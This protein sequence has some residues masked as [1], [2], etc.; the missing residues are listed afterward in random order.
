MQTRMNNGNEGVCRVRA[1]ALF[2]PLRLCAFALISF[3][4]VNAIRAADWPQWRGPNRDGVVPDSKLP[5]PLP[6]ELKTVWRVEIGEG[7]SSPI[8]VGD[9]V[10]IM[11]RQANEEVCLA[12][13]AAT[14]K[15]IWRYGYDCPFSVH[16]AAVGAGPGPKATMAHGNGRLFAF[17]ITE[18]LTCLD[19]ETGKLIWQHDF[20]KEFNSYWPETGASGSPLLVDGLCIA[21]I[22][23]ENEGGIRA[24]DQATGKE[25]WATPGDGPSYAAPEL[26]PSIDGQL[27]VTFTQG[28]LIGVDPHSGKLHW[29]WPFKTSYNQ[30]I[31]SPVAYKHLVIFAGTEQ[32]ITAIYVMNM[33]RPEGTIGAGDTYYPIGL[34]WENKEHS[35]Y[36]NSPVLIG[37]RLFFFSEKKKGVLV[38][39]DPAN[40]K[41]LWESEPR[42]GEYATLIVYDGKLLMLTDDAKLR[43]IEVSG[44][45][46][47]ELAVWETAPSSVWAHPAVVGSAIYIKDLKH[48]SRLEF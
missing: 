7:Y 39:L 47:V 11:T 22:G 28:S 2:A 34:Q 15:Q 32:P 25:I 1:N 26:M 30:N 41:T 12:L 16:S 5:D 9:R 45:K 36:M 29:K 4:T 3:F 17:G 35:S 42:L 14:G 21:Q 27:I 24:F 44:E 19:A 33:I 10:F 18:V 43:L 20:S 46:C 38:C 48:I 23:K 40:G 31:V 8:V 6:K 37:D 13:D